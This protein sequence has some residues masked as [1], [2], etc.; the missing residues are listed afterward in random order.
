MKKLTQA[1]TLR[2]AAV[3]GL[4]IVCLTACPSDG[5]NNTLP[6]TTPPTVLIVTP[7]GT[8]VAT[9]GDVVITFSEAMDTSSGT[10]TLVMPG[11]SVVYPS[12]WSANNTKYNVH[13]EY[14]PPE[15]LVTVQISGFK[16]KAGNP[17]TDVSRTFTTVRSIDPNARAGLYNKDI[18]SATDQPLRPFDSAN[19]AATFIEAITYANDNGRKPYTLVLDGNVNIPA[20]SVIDNSV[21]LRIIGLGANRTISLSSPGS[22][23]NVK[24][25]ATLVL[26]NNITLKGLNN[27]TDSLVKVDRRCSLIMNNGSA[28]KDNICINDAQ[29][30]GVF[31]S[32]GFF[33]MYGGEI[34][35]NKIASSPGGGVAQ[36]GGVHM[37]SGTIKMYGGKIS[38]NICDLSPDS[39][40]EHIQGGGVCMI[41][42]EFTMDGGEISG[43]TALFGGG[44]FMTSVTFTMSG[45][46][47]SD[48]N[49]LSNGIGGGVFVNK[50]T[51]TMSG[52]EI[53][54]NEADEG[55]GVVII[56]NFATYSDGEAT[57]IM[58]SGKITGNIGRMLGGGVYLEGERV[59]F[60]MEG[61]E[62]SDNT[63]LNYGAG[64]VFMEGHL[65]IMKGGKISA[66]TAP[67]GGGVAVAG[68]GFRMNGNGEISGNTAS[69]GGGV[70]LAVTE[71]VDVYFR[72]IDGT[73][74]GSNAP[75]I[76][77]NKTTTPNSGAAIYIDPGFDAK[78]GKLGSNGEFLLTAPFTDEFYENTVKVVD[79]ELV[80]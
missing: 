33:T 25:N 1:L 19:A 49:T 39:D 46:K 72:M 63:V 3:L 47:I 61:G 52:G 34:S 60:T 75:A 30:S 37:Y 11:N 77:Q 9:T 10:V 53:S 38:G 31:I 42:G 6:D 26:D 78:Y 51:F 5:G 43:N 79:G 65:F 71:S 41:G 57:F 27:N 7:S 74:Y 20:G 4:L 76:Q 64:G 59:T 58:D 29:G 56:S 21:T 23:F 32:D 16:D 2:N 44:V 68:G 15:T 22:L 28:I 24:G 40:P 36:G 17:M 80:P 14:L 12:E 54:G 62:I 67:N 48:N 45:G 70:Y 73:I 55:G 66:N 8:D 69:K 13:Y 35:G 50:G 18:I